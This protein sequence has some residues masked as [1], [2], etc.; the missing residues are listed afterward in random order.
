MSHAF[1]T[2][3]DIAE[4][5]SFHDLVTTLTDDKELWNEYCIAVRKRNITTN[6][7]CKEYVFTFIGENKECIEEQYFIAKSCN[8]KN[9]KTSSKKTNDVPN[10]FSNIKRRLSHR[11]SEPNCLCKMIM[12]SCKD[13]ISLEV[14]KEKGIRLKKH[15]S[16]SLI[17]Q[18][19]S[20][21]RVNLQEIMEKKKKIFTHK[22]NAS[23]KAKM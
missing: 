22:S 8:E 21:F 23:Q 17:A 19:K 14:D 5:P 20:T 9:S 7:G 4:P 10:H 6:A 13:E 16:E 11:M 2:S 15:A 1:N 3:D 12:K 18:R